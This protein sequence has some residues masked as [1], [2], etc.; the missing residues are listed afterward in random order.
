MGL[1]TLTAGGATQNDEVCY[2]RWVN[3]LMPPGT[4][5]SRLKIDADVPVNQAQLATVGEVG[6][7]HLDHALNRRVRLRLFLE[8]RLS[9]RIRASVS[10]LPSSTNQACRPTLPAVSGEVMLSSPP[11]QLAS[12]QCITLRSSSVPSK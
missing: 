4:E 12:L 8:L 3:W 7:Q 6:I 2:P 11:L 9:L 10:S 5:V 1:A